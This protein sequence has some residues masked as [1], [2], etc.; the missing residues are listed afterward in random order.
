LYDAVY[1]LLKYG[2]QQGEE[3]VIMTEEGQK[4]TYKP[5]KSSFIEGVDVWRLDY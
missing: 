5:T 2:R 3:Q 1:A 4:L